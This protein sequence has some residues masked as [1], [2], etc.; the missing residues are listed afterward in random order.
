MNGKEKD[1]EVKTT[2]VDCHI[3]HIRD[4]GYRNIIE[5]RADPKNCYI[6][7]AGVDKI[8]GRDLKR[9][10][11]AWANPYKVGRDG[12]L[13]SCVAQYNS[14]IRRKI[15]RGELNPTE[16]KGKRLGCWCV[17]RG[18]KCYDASLPFEEYVC[19]GQVLLKILKELEE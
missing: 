2:V 5:W 1:E 16:L 13:R 15:A 6:G 4:A 11:S 3:Q 18:E 17:G 10:G 9:E 19:H 14:Y 8:G 7:R 12:D